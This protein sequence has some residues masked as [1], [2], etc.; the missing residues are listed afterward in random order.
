MGG[1]R[2]EFELPA[3]PDR[4][5]SLL[6]D[7]AQLAAWFMD[8]DFVPEVGR[9]FM[10]WPGP[11]LPAV[12]GPISAVVLSMT[13]AQKLVMGWQSPH[14]QTEMTWTLQETR[15]GTRLRIVEWGHVGT[16]EVARERALTQLFDGNLRSLLERPAA[17]PVATGPTE[18]ASVAGPAAAV[19]GVPVPS[20]AASLT[21]A[22]EDSARSPSDPRRPPE[23]SVES[24]H[25][26]V[27]R[28][29]IGHSAARR[30]RRGLVW[31]VVLVVAVALALAATWIVWPPIPAGGSRTSPGLGSV[32]S[33]PGL[34]STGQ[35][36]GGQLPAPSD[37]AGGPIAGGGTAQS[38]SPGQSGDPTPDHGGGTQLGAAHLTV[39]YASSG[40]APY[41][42]TVTIT[43]DGASAG[44]WGSAGV[45]LSAL[46]LIVTPGSDV[47]HLK[48][49]DTVHCFY[50]MPPVASVPAGGSSAFSFTIAL[51]VGAMLA[52]DPVKGVTL[53]SAAC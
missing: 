7:R 13:P 3:A 38:V 42:V 34:G 19:I 30:G 15:Q 50:P 26:V 29:P 24:A 37:P 33:A 27:G 11:S 49:S 8:T 31:L 2:L 20:S 9:R 35:A 22:G 41:T 47:T 16:T 32:G 21:A 10:I 14:T 45:V 48:R 6:T 51:G 17:V 12:D 28:A 39:S 4:V 40:L 46:N 44:D 36:P 18:A 53:D 5:W 23:S 43:N 25:P 52:G 1:I